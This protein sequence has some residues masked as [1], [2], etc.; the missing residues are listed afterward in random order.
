MASVSFGKSGEATIAE[1]APGH[2]PPVVLVH[3]HPFDRS[4]WDPQ[5]AFLAARGYRV[6]VPDLRG[7][8]QSS[9]HPRVC[10]LDVLAREIIRLRDHRGVATAAFCGLSMG[11][12]IVLELAP[13]HC[14]RVQAIVL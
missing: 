4:M 3:G 12:Q 1:G 13:G 14:D 7:Y 11:R 10:T 2:A 8:G 5:A 6:I 9:V